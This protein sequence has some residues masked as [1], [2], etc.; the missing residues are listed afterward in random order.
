VASLPVRDFL[1]A[2]RARLCYH[3]PHSMST[4]PTR[5]LVLAAGLGTR[6]RPLSLDLPK[7]LMP[8][9]GAP[10]LGR[11]LRMLRAWGVTEA[12]VNV[13]AGAGEMLRWILANPVD[14][15]R[16][17]L[18]FEPDA[19]GTGGALVRA[20]WFVGDRPFWI[21][22]ADI[23]CALDPAPL[24]AALAAR[25]TVAAVWVDPARGPRTVETARGRVRCFRSATPGAPGTA[26]FCGVHLVRPEL[27][28][29]LPLREAFGTIVAAYEAAMNAGRRIAA[30]AIPGAFWADL[31]T[32]RQMVEAHRA[33]FDSQQPIANSQYR[34][35]NI[36]HRTSNIE[37]PT[38]NSQQPTTNIQHPTSNIEHRTSNIEHRTSNIEQ[39]TSSSRQPTADSQRGKG[40]ARPGGR[41]DAGCPPVDVGRWMVDVGC[42]SSRRPASL[43]RPPFAVRGFA[44]IAPDAVLGRGAVI[45]DSIVWP[46]A[47]VEPGARLCGAIVGRGAVARGVVRGPLVRADLVL[48]PAERA[49][50]GRRLGG[51]VSAEAFEPRGSDRTF[52]RLRGSR[53]GAMLIRHGR[54]RPENDRYAGHARFLAALGVRVPALLADRPAA[55]FVL[56]EDLGDRTLADVIAGAPE[57]RV[58]AAYVRVVLA[59]A[60]WHVAG[61]AAARRSGLGL[62]EPFGPAL[63]E[64]EHRL[65]LD[66][67]LAGRLHA[68]AALVAAAA[69]DLG[70]VSSWLADAPPVLLHRDLQSSNVLWTRGRPAFI[71]FQGMR[72]GPAMY[73]LASLLFD[74]YVRVPAAVRT[75]A[76]DAYVAEV[77]TR[78]ARPDVFLPAAVQ[79]LTQALGAYARLGAIRGA[80]RF[81]RHIPPALGLLEEALRGCPAGLPALEAIARSRS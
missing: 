3:A 2:V 57:P 11:T 32:P 7:P 47:R 62:E 63:Y 50:V 34:T 81:L 64:R 19:L 15:L 79:R 18:S 16:V 12:V 1:A 40:R 61:L 17:D 27:L 5:A 60:H 31:G 21:V 44:S 13:H 25:S 20:R 59:M 9:W 75:R 58:A 65:F 56:M 26:T 49:A 37:Q 78:R 67:Y 66:Q 54:E 80:E 28:R 73:D 24:R 35:S 42:C 30:V 22:N 52:L 10:P 70:R 33:A 53:R 71:D 6:M 4:V 38:A 29:F 45:E 69:R 46:G 43:V 72:S 55:R 8:F 14:G 77:G 68:P 48:A 23:A 74:P 76:L 36:E 41:P 51:D 39:P